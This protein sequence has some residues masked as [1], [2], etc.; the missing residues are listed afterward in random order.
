MIDDVERQLRQMQA[1]AVRER[2]QMQAQQPRSTV[3]SAPMRSGK[4]DSAVFTR[5][6]LKQQRGG[7]EKVTAIIVWLVSLLGSIAAFY[8]GWGP[9]IARHFLLVPI[10][11]GV[12]IQVV[13]TA[14]EWYYYDQ[15]WISWPARLLDTF[16]TALGYGP[17]L[18]P[19]IMVQL[20]ARNVPE[21]TYSAW[22]IVI[23]IA[24]LVAWF[25]ES[26]LVD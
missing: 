9:I 18:I 1:Q 5:V 24:Y 17:I 10:L 15:G 19:W 2:E 12:I 7:I 3:R 4:K 13:I 26:R 8:G 14:L 11:G 22:A 16:L 20:A 25:P 23:V 6:Q 21:P